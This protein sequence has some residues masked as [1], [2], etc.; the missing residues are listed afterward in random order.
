M[1]SGSLFLFCGYRRNRLK[2][3]YW[4]D[5]GFVLLYKV[6]ENGR[7]RWSNNEYEV[8]NLTREEFTW[9]MLGLS[10]DQFKV[11]KKESVI[12]N[13]SKKIKIYADCLFANRTMVST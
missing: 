8:K 2:A 13:A 11:I 10:I 7:F 1:F 3:L 9:L 12:I 4:E 6:G 5:D